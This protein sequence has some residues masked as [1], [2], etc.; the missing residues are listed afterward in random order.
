MHAPPSAER[1]RGV[2]S[3]NLVS[4][5]QKNPHFDFLLSPKKM[6]LIPKNDIINMSI[7]FSYVP[8][9]KYEKLQRIFFLF[10]QYL[11]S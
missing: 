11:S 4:A 3:I 8:R 1:P 5:N 10:L 7:I 2:T 6:T 9:R